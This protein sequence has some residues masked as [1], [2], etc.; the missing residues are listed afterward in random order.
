M[1]HFPRDDFA[2]LIGQLASCQC[3]WMED[4]NPNLG[5]DGVSRAW[6]ELGEPGIEQKGSSQ[7]L[8]TQNANNPNVTDGTVGGYVLFTIAIRAR[9][10]SAKRRATDVLQ[11]VRWGLRTLTAKAFFADNNLAFVRTHPIAPSPGT[12]LKGRRL[13]QATLDVVLAGIE[14][15]QPPDDGGQT[16]G[17]LNG[18]GAVPITLLP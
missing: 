7:Y 12:T 2:T 18:G 1:S 5:A 11:D 4:A 17:Q 15:G 8:R 3:T 6:V 14:G 9:S 16:I 13:L 10:Q